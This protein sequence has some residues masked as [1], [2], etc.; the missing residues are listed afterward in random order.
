MLCPSKISP[1][2]EAPFRVSCRSAWAPA[3]CQRKAALPQEPRL[4]ASRYGSCSGFVCNDYVRCCRRR[5]YDVKYK[6]DR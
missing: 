6:T 1:K 2:P 3:A 5:I 4:L